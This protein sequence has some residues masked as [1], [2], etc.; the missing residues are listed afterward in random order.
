MQSL[1][2]LCKQHSY[3]MLLLWMHLKLKAAHVCLS[4]FGG[5]KMMS[6]ALEYDANWLFPLR[7]LLLKK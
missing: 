1:V 2:H 3:T 6:L 5:E 4:A 7:V